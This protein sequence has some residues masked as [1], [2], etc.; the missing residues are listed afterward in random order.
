MVLKPILALGRLPVITMVHNKHQTIIGDKVFVGSDVQLIA[1]VKV[2]DGAT[3]A[4][5]TTVTKDVGRE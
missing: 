2:H 4:A 1:P 3:I 5:G